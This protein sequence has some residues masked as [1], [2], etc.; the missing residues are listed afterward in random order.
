MTQHLECILNY[1]IM[2][3]R[4]YFIFLCL[5]TIN[6]HLSARELPKLVKNKNGVTQF[7]LDEK[8][9][10][11]LAGEL[12]NSSAST[13][14]NMVPKWERLKRLN[15]NTVLLTVAWE[16]V[17]PEE[18]TY[19]FEVVD[20]LI[21]DARKHDLRLV[22][23]WFGS[24]KN[25]SSGYAPHWVMRDTQRF[26]RMKNA[27]GENRPYLSQFTP[28]LAEVES[29][30]FSA[31]M[32]Y[33]KKIDSE[34]QT[35]LMVQVE[36]EVGLLGDSRDRSQRAEELFKEEVPGGLVK[37]L[38]NNEKKILPEIIEQWK[39]NG[40][41]TKGSW[42]ELFG[43]ESHNLA[44]EM[45]MGWHYARH[46]ERIAS[47]GKK[48]YPIPMFVNAWTI[49]P[50]DPIPGKYPSGGPNARML[51]VYQYAAPSIDILA[52]DN[53]NDD[54]ISKLKEF[55]RN[56]NPIFVP[57]AVALFRGEK[58]SG[59]AKAFYTLS[60]FNAICFSPFGIDNDVYDDNHPLKDAYR[61][62]NNLMPLIIKEHGTGKMRGFFQQDKIRN[63]KV[64]FGDYEMNVNYGYSYQ[65]Y[66]LV[67]RLSEDEF[68]VSGNGINVS[69]RSKIESRPGIS[70]GT[71]REGYF[72]NGEWKTMK[73]AN[74]DEAM[75][76]VGGVKIPPVYLAEDANQN[77]VSTVIIK[78]IPVESSTYINRNIFDQ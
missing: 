49:Y 22:F 8:P 23:L 47:E 6:F 35:V 5:L 55:D 3:R 53:Y 34:H 14:E 28:E 4:L 73:Y 52:V 30:A 18:G 59:P 7:I 62:L 48:K 40:K 12:M 20:G 15:L 42:L 41:K 56:D 78:V 39:A 68:L 74:G 38:Q 64:D 54:Y 11:M 70:Y 63:D 27:R 67:I 29:K 57:E 76:G 72:V 36:N 13:V 43:N 58:W 2:K 25:G 17:E 46:I 9:Y 69:F 26:P 1:K 45:F 10:V 19:D 24:W 31:L 66:G 60:E 61:V 51:D 71:I 50:N 21:K 75:Q 32:D 65:G 33:I 37:Y 16:Q 77:L 44:D